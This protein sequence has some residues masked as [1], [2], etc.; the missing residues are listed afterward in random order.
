MKTNL[1]K[2]VSANPNGINIFYADTHKSSQINYDE[3]KPLKK[4]Q[5]ETSARLYQKVIINGLTQKEL[6]NQAMYGLK[7]YSQEEIDQMGYVKKMEIKFI[8]NKSQHFLNIWKHELIHNKIGSFLTTLFHKSDF[9]KKMAT[10]PKAISSW[11]KTTIT[12]KQLGIRKEQI[13]EKLIE[14]KILPNNYYQLQK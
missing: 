14:F 10:Y 3:T 7:S 11:D 4:L 12:L 8:H 9:A 5:T 13:E 1:N 6:F 2:T